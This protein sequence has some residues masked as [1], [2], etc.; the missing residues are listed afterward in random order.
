MAI[1]VAAARRLPKS[2]S[3]SRSLS[4]SYS[5]TNA[6][7]QKYSE[8]SWKL[9]EYCKNGN[10]NGAISILYMPYIEY[11]SYN[12]KDSE[13]NSTAFMWACVNSMI[14]V[15]DQ[16]I[17]IAME[18]NKLGGYRQ[19]PFNLN[20]QNKFGETALMYIC[21][22]GLYDQLIKL[23][24]NK[25]PYYRDA[26]A[27][28]NVNIQSNDGNTAMMFAMINGHINLVKELLNDPDANMY[29]QNNKGYSIANIR[30]KAYPELYQI[31]QNKIN[32]NISKNSNNLRE[33][34][35]VLNANK[36]NLNNASKKI[37]SSVSFINRGKI[38]AQEKYNKSKELLKNKIIEIAK[39]IDHFQ[40]NYYERKM[41]KFIYYNII[42]KYQLED[43]EVAFRK[44]YSVILNLSTGWIYNDS[45]EN[46]MSRSIGINE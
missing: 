6:M 8:T 32:E 5:Q 36:K 31:I 29:L 46:E 39:R 7:I 3:S 2:S 42:N 23:I 38:A 45:S 33:K 37:G 4:S 16:F 19:K 22:N 30:K 25:F 35:I 28:L 14:P 27:Y 13:Y 20:E 10:T 21:T 9:L 1:A 24:N 41:I 40:A 26:R 15:I 11:L 34:I 17:G 44:K 18:I 12:M 43:L